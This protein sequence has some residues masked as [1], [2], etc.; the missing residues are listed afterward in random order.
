MLS[1]PCSL[2]D[3]PQMHCMKQYHNM[4]IM[5]H[6]YSFMQSCYSEGIEQMFVFRAQKAAMYVHVCVCVSV[7]LVDG[8][9][10]L[11]DIF[12]VIVAI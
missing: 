9:I 2:D 11:H 12:I 8:L 3:D 10:G 4:V 7:R 5:Q 6:A 1:D